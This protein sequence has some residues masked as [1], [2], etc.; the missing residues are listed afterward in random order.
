[1]KKVITIS[2][3]IILLLISLVVVKYKFDVKSDRYKFSNKEIQLL[4]GESAYKAL[5]KLEIKNTLFV[6]LYIKFNKD[7]I[8]IEK[9]TYSFNGNYSLIKILNSLSNGEEGVIK[10]TIPEGFTVKQIKKRLAEKNVISEEEF[11]K[12][13]EEINDFYYYYPEGNLD[14]YLFPDTYEF[15]KNESGKSVVNKFLKRFLEKF[16]PEQYKDKELF[17]KKLILASVIEKEAGNKSEMNLVAS[18]FENRLNKEMKLQSCATVAYL[19]NYEKD[20][21]YYKDLQIDSPYNTYKYKGLP[22]APISN[23]G[24]A[25]IKA[26]FNPANTEYFYFV[27]GNNGK[28]HFSKTYK[29]HMDVQNKEKRGVEYDG[30][31]R[32]NR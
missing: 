18:V 20:Y 29:E 24:E 30:K 10:V 23:P 3:A 1:M 25:S 12:A 28:H 2:I 5:E 8:K 17:Y 16:P 26:S 9:G 4:N 15:Y 13:V 6:K 31:I 11:D 14:G 32:V 19:F 21:I 27:L 7:K 22:P